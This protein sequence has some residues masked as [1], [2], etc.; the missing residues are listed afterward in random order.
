M[1]A[2]FPPT[3]YLTEKLAKELSNICINKFTAAIVFVIRNNPV[4]CQEEI[5]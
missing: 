1:Y 5:I 3:I 2:F 4:G